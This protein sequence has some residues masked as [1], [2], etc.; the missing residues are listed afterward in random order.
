MRRPRRSRGGDLLLLAAVSSIVRAAWANEI[1]PS[2]AGEAVPPIQS[3]PIAP[4]AIQKSTEARFDP[5]ALEARGISPEMAELFR[6]GAK[7]APG[8]QRVA[9]IL[10]GSKAGKV[11]AD[12]DPAGQLCITPRFLSQATLRLPEQGSAPATHVT[13]TTLPPSAEALSCI[14]YPAAFPGAVVRL[15]PNSGTVELVVPTNALLPVAANQDALS[16]IQGGAAAMINYDVVGNQ[17]RNASGHQHTLFA[18]T[19]IGVN[20]DNWILRTRQSIASQDNN[21]MQWTQLYAYGQRSFSSLGAVVQFG[22]IGAASPVFSGVSMVGVQIFPEDGLRRQQNAGVE[23]HG[24]ANTEATVEVRQNNILLQTVR[25]PAGPFTLT[26]VPMMSTGQD[27]AVS[28]IE[29]SGA[30]HTFTVPATDLISPFQE[31]SR[32]LSAAVGRMSGGAVAPGYDNEYIATVTATT[33]IGKRVNV[34]LGFLGSG[35]YTAVGSTL[36]WAA[37]RALSVNSRAIVAQRTG[38][39]DSLGA[40]MQVGASAAIDRG[41]SMS[42][43][44]AR[45]TEGYR[46]IGEIPVLDNGQVTRQRGTYSASLAFPLPK[47]MAV[48]LSANRA[49]YLNQPAVSSYTMGIS[50][51]V[52]GGNVSLNLSKSSTGGFGN[53]LFATYTIPLGKDRSIGVTASRANGMLRTGA[54]YSDRLSDTLSVQASANGSSGSSDIDTALNV[55]A[56]PRY[57]QTNLGIASA[58]GG[59]STSMGTGVRGGIAI[60]AGGVTLSPYPIQETFGI[61]SVGSMSGVAITTPQGKVWTDYFGHAV[62]PSTP[63]Y[64]ESRVSLVT[65]D[66]PRNVDVKNAIHTI[67]PARGTVSQID[68]TIQKVNRILLTVTLPDN[69]PPSKGTIITDQHGKFL[70]VAGTNGSVFLD[71]VD[72]QTNVLAKLRDGVSCQIAWTPPKEQDG[73]AI[74]ATAPATCV[75]KIAS[76]TPIMQP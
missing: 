38:V 69:T 70:T 15:R 17:S 26:N 41:P 46:D 37:T 51:R 31:R 48:S 59:R 13:P 16:L 74:Y 54:T 22:Q 56:L 49:E 55:S 75:Q 6:L 11:D 61:A 62:V 28:V 34:S 66:L 23:I 4:A 68:F 2:A 45:Q 40:Q 18:N 50:G 64:A 20:V 5:K 57:F 42:V 53:S 1:P 60:H 27:I 33:P 25:L 3:A 30:T 36:E 12:F 19:E 44:A 72:E 63:A 47:S 76:P 7:F 9:L 8:R 10:N 35:K 67:Q 73:A 43:S 14:D 71:N 21:K 52:G 24:V 29:T 32:S 65:K 58:N 39:Q